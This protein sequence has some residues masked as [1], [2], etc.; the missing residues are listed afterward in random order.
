[1]GGG[2]PVIA[3]KPAA[4]L[5][6]LLHSFREGRRT[7]PVMVS[8]AKSLNETQIPARRPHFVILGFM[9]RIQ[10]SARPALKCRAVVETARS[11]SRSPWILGTSPRMTKKERAS[12]QHDNAARA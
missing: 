2:I 7:N 4:E 8:V 10:P 5:S 1:M 9:P 12:S 11:G 3:G 6:D